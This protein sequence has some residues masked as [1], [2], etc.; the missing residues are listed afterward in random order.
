MATIQPRVQ[1]CLD[2]ETKAIYDRAAKAMGLS[3]SRLIANICSDAADSI[4]KVTKVLEDSK[5]DPS[6]DSLLRFAKGFAID[7]RQELAGHQVDLEDAIAAVKSKT[8][9]KGK[10]KA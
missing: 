8:K 7:A 6:P 2:A 5:A 3:T 9:A 10:P 4:V 1:V